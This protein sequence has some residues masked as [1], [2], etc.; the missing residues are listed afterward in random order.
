MKT[1]IV[2]RQFLYQL[3]EVVKTKIKQTV[4]QKNNFSLLSLA[5]FFSAESLAHSCRE[6]QQITGIGEIP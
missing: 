2:L 1:L 4:H 6:R 5:V 3:P